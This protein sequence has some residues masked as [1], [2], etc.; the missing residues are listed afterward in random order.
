M[1]LSSIKS[2][3]L[4]LALGAGIVA[5]NAQTNTFPAS[6]NAGVGT[7]SPAA[8]LDVGGSGAG[9]ALRT[10]M[11]RQLEGNSTGAG[12]FLGV[13][14]W[15]T[16]VASFGGKMFSIEETFYG[17]LNSS[18]EFYRGG[19]MTGGFMTFTTN[20][21]TERMRI[22]PSGN[23]GIGVTAPHT[24]LDVRGA[25]ASPDATLQIVGVMT[26]T[27]LL[28]Q[29]ADGGV[30]R[31]QGGNNSLK[32]LVGGLSDQAATASGAEAVRITGTGSMGVGTMD[33]N[34]RLSVGF[35]N[36]DQISFFA[37]EDNR[38]AIQT[39]LDG[40]PA[41]GYGDSENVLLLQPIA[42]SVGIGTTSNPGAYRLA[43]NGS[44]RAH[45]IVVDSGWSDYVFAPDYRLAPLSEIEQHIKAEGHLPD[46]PSAAEVAAHGVTLGEMQAKLLA[47][48]EELTLHQIEQ[49]KRMEGIEE[50]NQRLREM[51]GIR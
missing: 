16:Q 18:I 35:N 44:I 4:I 10:V 49:E 19:G 8:N 45:E 34:G 23:V 5:I 42:G 7:T 2:A 24:R 48:I 6:G 30:I 20:D 37:T 26:S 40:H 33:P 1:H 28:G 36:D 41:G 11:A 13:R 21:G 22:D 43:V 38:L 15:G 3:L 31:G 39:S 51:M 17:L 47:K 46:I 32:F 14:A 9:G 25:S 29:D 27:L 12:T 50:E